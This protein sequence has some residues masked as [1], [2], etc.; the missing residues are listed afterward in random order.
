MMDANRDT[1]HPTTLDI[2]LHEF[3][4]STNLADIFHDKFKESPRTFMW[5]TKTLDYILIDPSLIAAVESIGYL[6]THEGSDTNH[7]YTLM[8]LNDNITHQGIV[9]RPIIT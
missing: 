3:I 1:H 5:G 6:G 7:V 8:D 9:H 2:E 4:E